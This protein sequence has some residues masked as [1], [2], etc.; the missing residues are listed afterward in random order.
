MKELEKQN[1]GQVRDAEGIEEPQIYET[2]R[3]TALY[4]VRDIRPEDEPF[5]FSSWLRS[6]RGSSFARQVPNPI[7]YRHQHKLIEGVL[8]H[9]HRVA[10]IACNPEDREQIF[11]YVIGTREAK[12]L[13]LHWIYVKHP[14]RNFGLARF[15][16]E[17]LLDIY[18]PHQVYYTARVK[19]LPNLLKDRNY[20]YHPYAL[21]GGVE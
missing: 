10:L 14:L 15:L 1:Q 3:A 19:H 17:D 18:D 6:Y 9:P 16:E 13:Y 5:I 2:Q 12:N 4:E 20:I 7:Y 8:N 21:F 11:G